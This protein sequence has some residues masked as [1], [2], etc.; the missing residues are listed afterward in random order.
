MDKAGI[1]PKSRPKL[2]SPT[3]THPRFPGSS[4]NQRFC[5]HLFSSIWER[6]AKMKNTFF[7]GS[8][9]HVHTKKEKTKYIKKLEG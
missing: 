5:Q 7:G 1:R 8:V 3:Q 9:F 6:D 4:E 2:N